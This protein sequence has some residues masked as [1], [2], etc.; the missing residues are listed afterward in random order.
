MSAAGVA[1][2]VRVGGHAEEPSDH[3]DA[4]GEPVIM[5]RRWSFWRVLRL[6]ATIAV[7]GVIA[8][9]FVVPELRQADWSQLAHI[10]VP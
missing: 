8:T 4:A 10:D 3:P 9:Y 6:A 1:T 7:L 5:H 2:S